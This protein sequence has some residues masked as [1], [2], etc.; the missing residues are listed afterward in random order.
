MDALELVIDQ[1]RDFSK[2]SYRLV[3]D[4]TNLMAK[5]S[6]VVSYSSNSVLIQLH[7][8]PHSIIH[9][10]SCVISSWQWFVFLSYWLNALPI[11]IL[12]PSY[13]LN[14]DILKNGYIYRSWYIIYFCNEECYGFFWGRQLYFLVLLVS[15]LTFY[16]CNWTLLEIGFA[17]CF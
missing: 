5:V 8:L 13:C 6:R 4:V 17:W 14:F 11:N 16:S 9:M 1:L 3:K 10:N 7:L 12:E 15:I 2:D